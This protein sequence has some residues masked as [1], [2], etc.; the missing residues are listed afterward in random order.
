[1]DYKYDSDS[2][3]LSVTISKKPFVYAE[4]MGDFVVHF[5]K[6]GKPVY[7]EILNAKQFTHH[8]KTVIPS[9][10]LNNSKFTS[11]SYVS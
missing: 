11:Q 3:I 1:M 4:E 7:I 10:I 6:N 9:A 5:D 2:D 8:A